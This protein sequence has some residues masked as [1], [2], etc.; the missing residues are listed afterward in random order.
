MTSTQ[1]PVSHLR[2]G[3]NARGGKRDDFSSPPRPI[4]TQ[5]QQ[6]YF[7]Q[8][9]PIQTIFACHPLECLSERRARE[10][11]ESRKHER[12]MNL[13][14]RLVQQKK[15][16]KTKRKRKRKSLKPSLSLFKNCVVSVSCFWISRQE[17]EE[18][19]K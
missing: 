19:R 13:E 6:P 9:K 11:N 2:E 12:R 17:E 3:I 16:T 10:W 14:G 15:E 8:K 5:L 4:T 7:L 1:T 18:T